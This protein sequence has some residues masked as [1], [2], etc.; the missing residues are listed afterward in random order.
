M[1]IMLAYKKGSS[2]YMAT[3]TAIISYGNRMSDIAEDN[4]KIRKSPSGI[5]VGIT[6]DACVRQEIF[7]LL[8][9]FTLDKYGDLTQKHIISKII[10]EIY[11]HLLDSG[12]LKMPKDEPPYMDDRILLVYKDKIFLINYNFAVYRYKKYISIGDASESA[13]YFLAHTDETKD[14]SEQLVK[15]LRVA[16]RH[17]KN[18]AAPFVTIDT[19]ESGF[20][21]GEE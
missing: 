18:V 11:F 14:I 9:E 7:T 15:M 13:A 20:R 2:V 6:G 16:E 8:D 19:E 5:L 1:S 12:M 4:L 10:P 17:C 21:L 3:D